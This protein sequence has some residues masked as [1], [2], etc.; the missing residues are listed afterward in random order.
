MSIPLEAKR[1]RHKILVTE[2]RAALLSLCFRYRNT[3]LNHGLCAVAGYK[4]CAYHVVN[5]DPPYRIC[6][7]TSGAEL[8]GFFRSRGVPMVFGNLFL[9]LLLARRN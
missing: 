9:I 1:L 4:K 5:G 6:K 2:I 8:S 7:E 3:G